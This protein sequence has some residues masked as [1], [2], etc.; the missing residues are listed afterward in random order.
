MAMT[1]YIAQAPPDLAALLAQMR[2]Q[3]GYGG[4]PAISRLTGPPTRGRMAQGR[5]VVEQGGR[6]GV[7]GRGGNFQALGPAALRGLGQES[8]APA[9]APTPLTPAT[10]ESDLIAMMNQPRPPKPPMSPEDQAA[11][12]AMPGAHRIMEYGGRGTPIQPPVESPSVM[13]AGLTAG[14]GDVSSLDKPLFGLRGGGPVP[15]GTPPNPS[16]GRLPMPV[17]PPM[18]EASPNVGGP[19]VGVSGL[20]G[21]P[22]SPP[23]GMGGASGDKLSSMTGGGLMSGGMSGGTAVS[24]DIAAR[25]MALNGRLRRLMPI[26]GTVAPSM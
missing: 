5:P 4:A 20:A 12:A 23:R 9:G 3:L 8:A 10:S 11:I 6:Q 13:S 16:M 1:N 7:M 19:P 2:G 15:P 22:A 21:P 25:R 24:P 18:G 26:A 17:P 14:E